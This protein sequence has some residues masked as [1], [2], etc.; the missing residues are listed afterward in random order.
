MHA[1]IAILILVFA[2]LTWSGEPDK[3]QTGWGNEQTQTK[4]NGSQSSPFFIG[5]EVTTKKDRSETEEERQEKQEK[6]HFDKALVKY[7][8]WIAAFTLLLFVAAAVQAGLFVWQ[9]RL[10]Q[11]G[12]KDAETVA[13][14]AQASAEA[15]KTSADAIM[16]SERAYVRISAQSPGVSFAETSLKDGGEKVKMALVSCSFAITNH[17][18]TPAT[19]TS[20]AVVFDVL[21]KDMK[22]NRVPDYSKATN[23]TMK[24]AFLVKDEVTH[25]I[26][27]RDRGELQDGLAIQAGDKALYV[28]GYVDYIDVFGVKHRGGFGLRYET[29]RDQLADLNMVYMVN[30]AYDYDRQRKPGEGNDWGDQPPS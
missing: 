24:G 30:R 15:A 23:S 22:P 10:I 14:A 12:A 5:G 25:W 7:T 16:L 6:S 26:S 9:L 20:C 28:Y 2:G 1:L 29:S 19:V 13:R 27:D 3:K 18:S 17:G 21:P 11:R 8:F 4:Q